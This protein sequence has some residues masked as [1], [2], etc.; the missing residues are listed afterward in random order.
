MNNAGKRLIHI[1][2]GYCLGVSK[3]IF[4]INCRR[5][6]IICILSVFRS[7][8]TDTHTNNTKQNMTNLLLH[9][10]LANA[11]HYADSLHSHYD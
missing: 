7:W 3:S 5:K 9:V 1:P 6:T 4:I 2:S 8:M 10:P 11:K